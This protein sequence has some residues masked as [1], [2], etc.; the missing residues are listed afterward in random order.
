MKTTTN[1]FIAL[2]VIVL[3]FIA[4]GNNDTTPKKC[5]CETKAHLEAGQTCACGGED[6]NCT[7]KPQHTHEWE[8][9]V[10]TPATTTTEGVETETCTTCGATNGTRPIAKLQ[11]QRQF[12]LT[13]NGKT[14]TITDTRTGANDVDLEQLGIKASLETA[15]KAQQA[16]KM[17][18]V[19]N[20]NI[21]IVIEDTT[22]YNYY[23]A[24]SETKCGF[25]IAFLLDPT[26]TAADIVGLVEGALYSMYEA[27]Y[28]KQA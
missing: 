17:L 2:A 7:E 20:R 26:T 28:P 23:K 21:E 8:W 27:P 18:E 24:Y 10:T 9:I 12:T 16:P 13:V 14:V 6:C 3:A 25:H 19:I 11:I 4:C 1:R 5:E 15:L 22:D